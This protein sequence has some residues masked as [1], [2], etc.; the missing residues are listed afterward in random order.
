MKKLIMPDNYK[1]INKNEC[2]LIEG[3]GVMDQVVQPIVES[4]LNALN[5]STM[6]VLGKAKN[7]VDWSLSLANRI[8]FPISFIMNPVSS[9]EELSK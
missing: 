9:T 6:D 5:R 8:F 7:W 2:N 4:S 1:I 3:G